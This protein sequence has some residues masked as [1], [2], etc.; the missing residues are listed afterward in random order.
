M[1]I[2]MQTKNA[3]I[4]ITCNRCALLAPFARLT[5]RTTSDMMRFK[6]QNA[7]FA[8]VPQQWLR[9]IE[10]VELLK[11][12]RPDAWERGENGSVF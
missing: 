1:R 8:I 11:L 12:K 9:C 6:L 10:N 7:V 2:K 3:E 5:M 4:L